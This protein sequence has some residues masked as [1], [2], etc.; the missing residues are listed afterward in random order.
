MTERAASPGRRAWDRLR[1]NRPA[2]AALWVLGLFYGAA[3]LAPFLAPRGMS[4]GDRAAPFHPPA[5]WHARGGWQSAPRAVRLRHGD[6]PETREFAKTPPRL[7]SASFV[8]GDSY[9]ILPGLRGAHCS[10]AEAGLPAGADQLG[11]DI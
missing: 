2:L 5:R 11:R 8:T 1:R 10:R 9:D 7:S 6:G 4:A 3:L